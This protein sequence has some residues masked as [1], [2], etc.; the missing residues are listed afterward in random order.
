MSRR[1]KTNLMGKWFGML[2]VS[3]AFVGL[4]GLSGSLVLLRRRLS[5]RPAY[6]VGLIDWTPIGSLAH[7]VELP[8]IL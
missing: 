4:L 8:R 2:T 5:A 7:A 3:L 6:P 1:K